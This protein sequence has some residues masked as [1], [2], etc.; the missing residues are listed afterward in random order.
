MSSD[1]P[2]RDLIVDDEKV[3]RRLVA[4][5]LADEGFQCDL[6]ADGDEAAQ[7]LAEH[8]YDLL[9]TDLKMPTAM[10]TRWCRSTAP[11]A[12][13]DHHGPH[14]RD[15]A[16]NRPRPALP[17][18]RRHHLQAVRRVPRRRQGQNVARTPY[19][20]SARGPR[21]RPR[22]ARHPHHPSLPAWKP[23]D[24]AD[25]KIDA[26][27]LT[28]KLNEISS[29]LPISA[30]AL[31]VYHMTRSCDWEVSQIAAAIQRDASLSAEV[32]RLAN[33][34]FYNN[35][36]KGVVNLEQAVMSIRARGIC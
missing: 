4:K 25:L 29:V 22:L 3:I 15:G 9:V 6:A 20:N 1:K 17:R 30:A 14:Q 13:A 19:G 27:R 11:V 8:Q 33:S 7:L 34:S 28:E 24:S 31:D 23:A 12:A 2:R 18:R 5:A 36:G 35:T 10:A 16:Q 21:R 26:A 32:L